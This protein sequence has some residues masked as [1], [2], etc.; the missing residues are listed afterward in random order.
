MGA[1]NLRLDH[2]IMS[3]TGV[4]AADLMSLFKELPK[5]IYS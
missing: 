5:D 2:R 1:L 4:A 3:R